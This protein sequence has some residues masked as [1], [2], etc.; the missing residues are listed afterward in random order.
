[1][2]EGGVQVEPAVHVHHNLSRDAL[3]IHTLGALA[4]QGASGIC[5]KKVA[6]EL[7]PAVVIAALSGG[8][9]VG[10]GRVG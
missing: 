9:S 4:A 6:G 1:L 10:W 7:V 3:V 5:F 2:V 8:W